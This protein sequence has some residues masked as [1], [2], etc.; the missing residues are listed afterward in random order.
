MNLG[1]TVFRLRT[2]KSM[3][4][5]EL[6][7]ALDVSRQSVSKWET[8]AS[9]PELDKLVKIGEI[10]GVSLD[11]LVFGTKSAATTNEPEYEKRN[12]G[13]LR[14][15]IGTILLSFGFLVFLLI[16]ILGGFLSGVLFSL[17][18]ILCAFVCFFVKSFTALW[19]SWAV[20]L[21]VDLYLHYATGIS[22]F[23]IFSP[24]YYA[25]SAPAAVIVAWSMFLSFASLALA[26]AFCYRKK[27]VVLSWRNILI[28]SG[29]WILF[30]LSRLLLLPFGHIVINFAQVIAWRFVYAAVDYLRSGILV[31]ALV[32]MF[33]LVYTH[34]NRK[35]VS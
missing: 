11:E 33:R 1:E 28:A 25:F 6:A 14:V 3:S 29:L 15:I 18:L 22:M 17:P 30:F 23:N 13:S 31:Y 26:T 19:C 4:Q 34:A 27:T 5:E 35:N 20:Y 7:S 21:S 2:E 32:Y 9:T 16:T 10:F 24:Y 8:N 12:S